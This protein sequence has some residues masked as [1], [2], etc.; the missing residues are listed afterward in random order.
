M[1]TAARRRRGP[2]ERWS[3]LP[4]SRP[5][6]EVA[7]LVGHRRLRRG[8]ELTARLKTDVGGP[9]IAEKSIGPVLAA[10]PTPKGSALQAI[11]AIRREDV[12]F[13]SA[14]DGFTRDLGNGRK[15]AARAGSFNLFLNIY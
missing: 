15:F 3:P 9:S 13:R 11:R 4:A 12:R 1:C 14:M 2:S 5:P 6:H 10:D 8:F 7:E